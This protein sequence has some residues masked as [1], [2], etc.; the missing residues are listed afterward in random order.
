LPSSRASEPSSVLGQSPSPPCLKICHL[1]SP[2]NRPTSTQLPT[3]PPTSPPP[4]PFDQ[5]HHHTSTN[6]T[7]NTPS[8]LL[9]LDYL[10]HQ[11]PHITR[12]HLNLLI[13]RQTPLLYNHH[14]QAM[15]ARPHHQSQWAHRY[16]RAYHIKA[17]DTNQPASDAHTHLT[18]TCL[19]TPFT[20]VVTRLLFSL[21]IL[22]GTS[23]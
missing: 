3:P 2:T 5:C 10:L 17:N 14:Q 23:P 16:T 4:D 18:S 13:S 6:R 20:S 1:W 9:P 7:L 12:I 11:L 22:S 19:L 15:I 8:P 21:R